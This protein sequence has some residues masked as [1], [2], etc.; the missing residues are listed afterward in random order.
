V[1]TCFRKRWLST[2]LAATVALPALAVLIQSDVVKADSAAIDFETY[3]TGTVNGQDGWSSTGSAGS[4]CA[5]YDHAVVANSGA[6]V[7]F[8]AKSLRISN[9]VTSGCFGDQTFSKSLLQEAGETSAVND[10]W[11]GGTRQAHFDAQ[12]ALASVVP[13]AQQPGLVMSV[14]PDR[15]D[16]A[17]MSYLRFEDQA[18]GV[19][20]FFDDYQDVIPFGG[21]V[22]DIN[23]CSGL[24]DFTEAD[25][26]TLDRSVPHIIRFEI[27]FI[28]G[29]RNDV[30]RIY[31]DGVLKT[32][33]TSWEDYFRYC[34]G[35]PT[36]PVD[37]LLF[38]SGGAAV[39]ANAGKGFLIDNISLNSG[40]ILAGAPTS[41]D[42]CKKDGWKAFNN[43]AFKNQGDC[44]SFVS[45]GK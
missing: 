41:K 11:S 7:S 12:F 28:D 37:S 24:D 44:I 30:V 23:G 8:G 16:G 13:G 39:P 31:I 32:T 20:T 43:P 36:R 25:I 42:Q 35:N 19:H 22:G 1:R 45:T 33:G 14:S 34:E 21:A 2:A 29:P 27:D 10:G 40:A 26:A 38:R 3:A 6:P 5:V 17:R 18:D 9:A 4:G 15:G